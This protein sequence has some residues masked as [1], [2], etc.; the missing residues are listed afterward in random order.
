MFVELCAYQPYAMLREPARLE[1]KPRAKEL[2]RIV[3]G[4]SEWIGDTANWS[5][6]CCTPTVAA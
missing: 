2:G 4:L 1:A 5:M 6:T 3:N